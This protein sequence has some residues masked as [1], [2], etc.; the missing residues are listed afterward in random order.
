[1]NKLKE[2]WYKIKAIPAIGIPYEQLIGKRKVEHIYKKQSKL[3]NASG[4][5]CIHAV[6]QIM[7]TT[8]ATYFAYAGTLLGIVRDNRLIKWDSDIDYGV[9]ID[10]SFGW[11]DLQR[12][13]ESAGCKKVREFVFEGTIREQAYQIGKLKVDFFG[14][15]LLQDKML[16]YSFER[17]P[18]V[19]YPEL[20]MNSVY[21]EMHP[22]VEKTKTIVIEGIP[23]TIPVNAEELL[24]SIYTDSWRVP[25]PNWKSHSADSAKLLE[26]RYGYSVPL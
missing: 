7:K 14:Q 26:G 1:M 9:V 13:M 15:T 16:M 12:A 20:H 18:R 23:V 19:K 22:K 24:E 6:E 10:D 17:N 3:L 11:I 21:E 4:M 8:D 5:Q 25:N 2:L